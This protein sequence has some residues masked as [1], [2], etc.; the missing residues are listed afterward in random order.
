MQN[1]I[2]WYSA[3]RADMAGVA[4]PGL[5]GREERE[6]R[7]LGRFWASVCA[8]GRF[9]CAFFQSRRV[10]PRFRQLFHLARNLLN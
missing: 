5:P 10:S 6:I 9:G 8:A 3:I 7:E 4:L 1:K 2:N